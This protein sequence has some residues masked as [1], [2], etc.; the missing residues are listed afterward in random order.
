LESDNGKTNW[1]ETAGMSSEELY[2]R[3][4]EDEQKQVLA[5]KAIEAAMRTAWDD[6]VRT[7]GA[8]LATRR[9]RRQDCAGPGRHSQ[10][11]ALSAFRP[12]MEREPAEMVR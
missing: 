11:L 8:S 1:A 6:K 5:A 9:D 2:R 12:K 4:V 10:I 3:I 7:L